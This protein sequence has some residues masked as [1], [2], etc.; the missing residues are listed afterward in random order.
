MR[1]GVS[2]ARFVKSDDMIPSICDVSSDAEGAPVT[3]FFFEPCVS[4]IKDSVQV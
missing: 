4:G 3:L 2:E 1:A